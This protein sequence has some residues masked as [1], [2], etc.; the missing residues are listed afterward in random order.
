M[1][2]PSRLLKIVTALIA[3]FIGSVF[4]DSWFLEP[5]RI[6]HVCDKIQVGAPSSEIFNKA[7]EFNMR[8]IE[9]RS[10]DKEVSL[11]TLH[12]GAF[13]KYVCEIQ[14]DGSHVVSSEFKK[15]NVR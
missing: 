3:V 5:N 10:N 12:G 4:I 11:I 7:K 6:E 8:F 9:S 13:G 1:K 15:M 14:H 2:N